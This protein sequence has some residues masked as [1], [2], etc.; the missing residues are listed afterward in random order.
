[1]FSGWSQQENL[2]N[3]YLMYFRHLMSNVF[4]YF[5]E[6]L[7]KTTS[8][9]PPLKILINIIINVCETF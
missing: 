8:W 6:V 1:M 5:L 3:Q 4:N 9:R 2:S 7:L